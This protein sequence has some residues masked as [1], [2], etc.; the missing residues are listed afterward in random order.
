MKNKK[1]V[2]VVI[3]GILVILGLGGV[4]FIMDSDS[5]DQ[6]QEINSEVNTVLLEKTDLK[7]YESFDGILK[8]EDDFRIITEQEGVLTYLAPE[9]QE[10]ARGAEIYRIYRSPEASQ[11]LAADQ[12][13]ASA[14]A[15]IAQ[16]ELALE[17][18]N[19]AP[20]AAQ[21]ASAEAG[22]A[23]AELALENLNAAPTA[24]QIASAEAGIAQAEL[25]FENLNAAPTAA[26]IASAEAAIAQAELALENLNAAPTAAQIAAA[27]SSLAQAEAN[28]AQGA[29]TIVS[30]HADRLIARQSLCNADI[31]DEASWVCPE[32]LRGQAFPD[33]LIASLVDMI[34]NGILSPEANNLLSSQ[35]NYEAAIE[36][37]KTLEKN[38][39]QALANQSALDEP[40]TEAQ[41]LQATQSL[42]SAKEHRFALDEPSTE[43]QLL[44]VTQSLQSAKEQRSALDERP[45][46]AQ[47]LQATQALQ[48][49]KEQ[50][51][52]LD[53]APTDAQLLQATQSLQSAMAGLK[54]AQENR[55][56]YVEGYSASILMFGDIPAWR[57]M[58]EGIAPGE[59]IKQLKLN[60][61]DLG[62]GTIETLGNDLYFNPA[63]TAAISKLQSDMNLILSGEIILGEVIFTPGTSLVK[64]SSSLQTVG[65]K[66]NAGSELFSLTPIE[67][68]V[69]QT[70]PDGSVT[71][72]RE[73]LQIVEIQVDVGDRNLVNEGTEVEI[74]LPDESLVT[75]IVREVGNLAVVP[76]EGDPFL[77][78]LIGV[79]SST[80]YF[81]WT[82]ATF[83]INVTSEL[84]KGV[85]AS[86][87]NGLLA[88]LSGGYA[89]EIV[90]ATGTTLIPIETGIYAD[91]WVEITGPGLRSGT[92]IIVANQ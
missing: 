78:V 1:V 61:I 54:T 34:S 9:G 16:A 51:Y 83:T 50:R 26:Q 42:Q 60:L 72:L 27:D 48:S 69:T 62:Y 58:T 32:N 28:F 80:E 25:A 36:S 67:K 91:G 18:L 22:I 59:D 38:L 7:T 82:G 33:D 65:R 14:E 23:Q 79:K 86:P 71:I 76:Q 53:E 21:I 74:E 12:Q 43:A 89:V 17:N 90:T 68:V 75:G 11:L 57:D 87:V 70:G 84:A 10:L 35:K 4:F 15:G 46:E 20:T 8:Y 37:S 88:I 3:G 92:E 47:L 85:L 40:P 77:E 66:L 6:T 49:A 41:L 81:E 13:I 45:T 44:Q 2:L 5:S 64:S 31:L 56:D 63:T 30:T 52:A 39:E 73:S 19:A 29:N 24:A 55:K